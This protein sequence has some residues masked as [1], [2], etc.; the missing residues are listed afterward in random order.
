MP[1]TG[2]DDSI[3]AKPGRLQDGD[4]VSRHIPDLIAINGQTSDYDQATRW[5]AEKFVSFDNS[6]LPSQVAD[7]IGSLDTQL[8]QKTLGPLEYRH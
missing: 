6:I 2:D 5:L 7:L 1:L 3:W 8:G 4:G